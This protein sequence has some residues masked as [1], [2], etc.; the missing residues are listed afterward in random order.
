MLLLE[1]LLSLAVGMIAFISPGVTALALLSVIAAWATLTGI[2]EIM[3]AI[4]LR[5]EIEN[6]WWLSLAGLHHLR[7]AFGDSAGVWADYD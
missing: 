5:R 1:G 3:A 6:E 4:R 7:S 2:L